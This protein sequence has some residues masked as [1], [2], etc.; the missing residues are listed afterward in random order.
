MIKK[1]KKI[2]RKNKE[3]NRAI[4]AIQRL[5]SRMMVRRADESFGRVTI[6]K[7]RVYARP[8]EK[9]VQI[10]NGRAGLSGV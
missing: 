6:L 1:K 2:L 9:T 8:I 10:Q 3:M 5:F 4:E 7:E